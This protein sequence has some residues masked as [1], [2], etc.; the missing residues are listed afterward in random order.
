VRAEPS[1]QSKGSACR[2]SL[3]SVA[4]PFGVS[5]RASGRNREATSSATGRAEMVVQ[6]GTG[7]S[8]EPCRRSPEAAGLG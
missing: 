2:V 3:P 6:E 7:G 8:S 1:R 4:H 5:R